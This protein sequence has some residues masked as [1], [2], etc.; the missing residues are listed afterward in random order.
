MTNQ[1]LARWLLL[2]EW[3]AQPVRAMVAVGAIALGVTLG[4]AIHLINASAFN[5]FS[6]AVKSLSGQ[7]DLQVRGSSAFF[8]EQLFPLLAQHPDV[9]LANPVL[10]LNV[11]LPGQTAPLK[12][13]GV[14]VFRAAHMTPDLI[15]VP[16]PERP[17]DALADDAVFLSPAALETLHVQP[18][19]ALPVRVGGATGPGI[20][21]LRV[22]GGLL[23]ARSGQ[24]LAI[25]DIGAA[26]WRFQRLGQLSRVE[27]RLVTGIDRAAFKAELS[28]ALERQFPGQF[29]V[30]E[31]ADQEARSANMSRAYRVNLSVLALVAL[32]TGAFLVFS[33]QALSVIR[34]RSQ[35]AML[36]VL[37][38]TQAQLLRQVL[39][40]GA[41]LGVLGAGLGL[42]G[43]YA[44][45]ATALHF[46][47]G[48]L[49]GGYF[50]G[51]KPGVQ[52]APLA[53]CLFFV[54]GAGVALLGCAAPAWEAAR[55]SPAQA[56]KSGSEETSLSALR[57]PWPAAAA[58]AL[59][60]LATQGPP[61][62]NL[63]IFGYLSIALLLVGGIALMPRLAAGVFQWLSR[64]L[65]QGALGMHTPVPTLVLARLANAP[66]QAAIALGGV[67]SSFSLMVAMAIMV[68]S[69][70]ISVDQW[71]L[72]ILPADLYA[73]S[74]IG[75]DSGS[76]P[77][78]AQNMVKAIPGIARADFLRAIALSF[79]PARPSVALIA[80]PV[81]V[82]D[83]AQSMDIVGPILQPPAAGPLPVWVSEP[84]VDFYG[85]SLGK[86]IQLPLAGRLHECVVA[87]IW[88][89]YAR[90]AGAI[91]M[92]LSDYQAISGDLAI[93][94][95]ALWLQAGVTPA[96]IIASIR[97]L[98]F[99]ATL[100]FS[101]PGDLRALSLKIFD[102][103][104]AVTYLL[105]VIAIVIGLFGIAATFSAQTLA[106]AKEF[107]MMR[108]IGVTRRQ[109]LAILAL[110]G[111]LLTLIGIAAGFVLGW[112]ISLILVFIVNP[113]SFHWSMQMHLP[114][115]LLGSVALALLLA[116]ALTALASGRYALSGNAIRAVKE[117]W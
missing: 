109:I 111:G 57:N 9:A 84:V 115:G 43:G 3:R 32:F 106:R 12:I 117:D 36:R 62:W 100:D 34:R 40:E 50:A 93:S 113:Q 24:P 74:A 66:G 58:L 33:T 31:S 86:H 98:P 85:F 60:A 22:A 4:F 97:R 80:R 79:D 108:H 81:D 51:V 73:R 87:G 90:Q 88:R 75:S 65:G 77:P 107:G 72:H 46:F 92:R 45:A 42:A 23:H 16:A 94:D 21:T 101:E 18:G 37:G 63:P 52:F 112:V 96:R 2:G 26:Q 105:E 76:L 20:A 70:R 49:G 99:G 53:A 5:E 29:N 7:S 64:R 35:F 110:E 102:R 54:L 91:Q 83:P 116:S 10:E 59:A 15:G 14:D 28:E 27:L 67:L 95:M 13:L 61:L 44:M 103:S 55:A 114:W 8:D 38:W 11:A 69:F 89:D 71:L 17:F 78:A 48:D 82:R 19:A 1:L 56:L 30:T 39:L 41:V 6:S 25:M 68:S 104:F 47:G